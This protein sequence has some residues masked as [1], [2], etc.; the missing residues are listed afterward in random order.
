MTVAN[1]LIALFETIHGI[2]KTCGRSDDTID[3]LAVTKG[4]S[5]AKI[6]A[7]IEVGQMRFGENYLQEALPKI[8]ATR[9]FKVEWHFIGSIQRNKIKAIAENFAWVHSIADLNTAKRLSVYR[10]TE[11]PALNVCLQINLGNEPQKN[12]IAPSDALG[13]GTQIMTLPNLNLRGLMAI[14]P[15]YNDFALQQKSLGSLKALQVELNRQLCRP[16]DTLSMGTSHD[17]QVAIIQ[18]AT[19]IRVG[20]LIFGKRGT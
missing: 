4:Q 8:A 14:P 2:K 12:G 6:I 20:S 10:P 9:Q 15:I 19:I 5:I 11:L 16:L 13:L 3:V 1:N 18:G 17:F 7:A